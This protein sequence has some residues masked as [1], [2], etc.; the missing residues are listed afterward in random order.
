MTGDPRRRLPAAVA[1]LAIAAMAI[2][3]RRDGP[4]DSVS[5]G[6]W[7]GARPAMALAAVVV[8][9]VIA[10][11]FAKHRD[12]GYGLLHRAGTAT[13]VLLT[14]AAVLTP[15]G[16]L[17]FGRKPEPPR[18]EPEV[19]N[20]PATLSPRSRSGPDLNPGADRGGKSYADWLA[21]ALL[22]LILAAALALLVYV[23]VRLLSRRWTRQPITRLEFD[24]LAPEL[25][26]LAEAV[27]AGAEALEYEGDA[28]E[29]VIAC[30]S[31]MEMAVAA[32]GGSRKATDTPE[33]FL[34]RVTA[35][36]LIPDDP[37]RR[38][39]E[40]FREARFSRHRI[41][42]DKRDAAREALR[43]ISEHLRIRAEELA[44]ATSRAQAAASAVS[45]VSATSAA[46]VAAAGSSSSNGSA[47]PAGS[48]SDGRA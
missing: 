11:N 44:A 19:S 7:D 29:A 28:R 47:G 32:G 34:R 42:E 33:E 3:A 12:D 4:L 27:A 17:L 15:I 9:V 43:E 5:T 2:A 31:A 35:A 8:L 48:P 30:Y 26:Q 24:P 45:T 41:G 39:T 36:K 46:S 38:L 14:A 20:G 16:L 37:A 13:A 18:Q 10:T 21:L 40:L 6:L 23:L 22:Y 1:V 25:D